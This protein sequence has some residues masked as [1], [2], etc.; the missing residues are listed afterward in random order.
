MKKTRVL[1]ALFFIISLSAFTSCSK[2]ASFRQEPMK[3]E[4]I[5]TELY[6]GLSQSNGKIITE[7]Q[8]QMFIDR[9][10]TPRFKDGLTIVGGYGQWL[11]HE[12]KLIKEPIKI[13]IILHPDTPTHRQALETIRSNYKRQFH[14]ESVLKVETEAEVFL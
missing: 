12:G 6:F 14:Q 7:N 13:I 11:N 2:T 5:K 9:E 3:V 10:V 4:W 1:L 8:W